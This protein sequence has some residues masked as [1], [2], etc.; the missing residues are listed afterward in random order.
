MER[1]KE[2]ENNEKIYEKHRNYGKIREKNGEIIY[3]IV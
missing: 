1:K 3:K 2:R